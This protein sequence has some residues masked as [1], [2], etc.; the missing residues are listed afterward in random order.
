MRNN[1]AWQEKFKMIFMRLFVDFTLMLSVLSLLSSNHKGSNPK[2]YATTK[3][4]LES[5]FSGG[6]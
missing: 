4:L 6:L 3:K 1:L 5:N 2:Y